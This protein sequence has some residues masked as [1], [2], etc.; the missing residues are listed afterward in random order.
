MSWRALGGHDHRCRGDAVD[1]AMY[2]SRGVAGT[3]RGWR[4]GFDKPKSWRRHR[5]LKMAANARR[6][7]YMPK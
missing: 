3:G 5:H 1:L 6:M 2:E 4:D 7:A